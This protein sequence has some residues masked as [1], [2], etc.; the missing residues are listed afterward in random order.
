VGETP[1]SGD[2]LPAPTCDCRRGAFAP[3]TDEQCCRKSS[4]V[5]HA[6]NSPPKM[7]LAAFSLKESLLRMTLNK[8]VSSS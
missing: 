5:H 7:P 1:P 3:G 8:L 4:F 6:G 2:P